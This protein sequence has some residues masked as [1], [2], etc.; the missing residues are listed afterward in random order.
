MAQNTIALNLRRLRKAK[1]LT[2]ASL[3]EKSGLSRAAYRNIETGK[4]KLETLEA[5][6]PDRVP[7]VTV[8]DR[9]A[10]FSK[11]KYRFHVRNNRKVYV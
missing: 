7:I 2:Q 10:E 6:L 8:A 1:D 11:Y 3:A 9:F 4:L 5:A